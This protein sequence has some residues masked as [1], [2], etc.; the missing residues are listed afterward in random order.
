IEE[1]RWLEYAQRLRGETRG[2]F[3]DEQG[4]N[5]PRLLHFASVAG[6]RSL[7]VNAG[8]IAPGAAADFVVVDAPD[9]ESLI[10][11]SSDRAIR[12]TC[13]AGVWK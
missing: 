13:V 5:A 8:R 1:M 12:A 2:V 7:G 4:R 6:A 3:R 9:L 10:F 11:G